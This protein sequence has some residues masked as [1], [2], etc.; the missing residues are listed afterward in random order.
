MRPEGRDTGYLW[1][2]LD[3]ARAIESFVQGLEF[4]SYA[5][6]RKAQMAVERALEIIGEAA[7]RL[8]DTFKA[9]HPEIRWRSLI[10]QRNILAHEYGEI[11]VERVWRVAIENVPELYKILDTLIPPL[12]GD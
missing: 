1:D 3:A 5:D 9:A 10:G 12:P 2:M 11:L 7:R 6:D 4:A 8:S